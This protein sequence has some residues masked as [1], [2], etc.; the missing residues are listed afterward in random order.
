MAQKDCSILCWN[1]RGLNDGAKRASVRN[2]ITSSGATLVCL[3]ETKIENWNQQLLN[4]AVGRD[5]ATNCAF[6]P[7]VGAAGGILL[8][9]SERFF[10]LTPAQVTTHSVSAKITMLEEN[11][12]WCITGVYGPQTD[13]EKI[14]FMQEILDLKQHMMDQWLVLGDFN[15]IYRVEDKNN[16]RI[17]ISMLNRFKNMIDNL[18]LAPLELFGRRFMWCNNQQNPTMT[19]IDHFLATAEW[20]DLFP[21][22]DLQ[23][24]ASLGSDH[25]P[26]FLQGDTSFEFC[27][28]F[29]FE[30]YWVNMP[31]FLETVQT[32]WEQ[33]VNT[34][35]ALLNLHVKL[36][37][38]A[39]S[40][41]LEENKIQQLQSAGCHTTD[42]PA[43]TRKGP[44]E[45]NFDRG[46]S[47]V[48]K[49]PQGKIGWDG[50]GAEGEGEATLPFN[51][52]PGRRLKHTSIPY[53]CQRKKKKNVHKFF[54]HRRWD[55]N[56]TAG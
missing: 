13:T 37:R 26:L 16:S 12:S 28:G 52:D 11:V 35:N 44:G 5:L 30:A 15:L 9:A 25:C 10:R 29:R 40:Q 20:L 3:Q 48:Q 8:A 7:A 22:T 18:Q 31:G 4:E 53:F 56:H 51:L 50:G 6:L 42:C 33:P 38:T 1:V 19:K 23:A 17:N 46:G 41:N 21:R 49:I 39:R 47:S 2:L 43:R 45:A 24:L 32:A 55:S 14:A 54:A 27:R 36:L 34:Q